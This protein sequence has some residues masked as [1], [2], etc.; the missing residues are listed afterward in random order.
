MPE[1]NSGWTLQPYA[2]EDITSGPVV[3][4]WYRGANAGNYVVVYTGAGIAGATSQQMLCP[5]NSIFTPEFLH[6]SNAETVPGS[7]GGFGTDP[8]TLRAC[9]HGIWIYE[10]NIPG[11]LEGTLF[12]SL[13]WRSD[14]GGVR[15]LSSQAETMPE[16][17]ELE[18]G[19][20]SYAVPPWFTD[21]GSSTIE[22]SAAFMG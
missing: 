11:D 14:D 10:T 15:G 4:Y 16:M 18:P 9:D 5:G 19:L 7:C 1:N 12:A 3:A 6:I 22:C 13:E 21:D 17:A 20:D 2:E 8:G